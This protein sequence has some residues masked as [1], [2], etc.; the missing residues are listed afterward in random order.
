MTSEDI[1]DLAA[2]IGER[3][4]IDVAKWH[5]FLADAHLHTVLAEQFAPMLEAGG[6]TSAQISQVLGNI[7]V[8]MGGGQQEL[9]LGVLVPK[10][11]QSAL[12]D[13]LEEFQRR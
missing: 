7:S 12:V 10:S 5:L 11:C 2:E 6:V 9:S 4:Y 3:V 1:E 13:L 8:P